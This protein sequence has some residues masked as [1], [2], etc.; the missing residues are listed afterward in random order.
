MTLKEE[1]DAL[2]PLMGTESGEFYSRVK[3]IAD[4]YTSEGDKKMI[5]DFMDECL[6]EISGEI[7]GME[8]RTIKLQLQNIS[9]IISLS[10]IAK[11]YFGKTKEWLYQRI[12]GNVV[13]GKPCRFTAEE[14]DRFNHALKD[15]SQKIG[16]LRLSY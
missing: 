14:L 10:F 11:H 1:L 8:E 3:H 6:N 4:T 9:E 2:R 15:I 5:A 12:N 7:A 13:N 16:S